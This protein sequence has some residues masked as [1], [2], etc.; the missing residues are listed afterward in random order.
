MRR[1]DILYLSKGDKEFQEIIKDII[2][3]PEVQK[4]KNYKVHGNTTCFAHCYSVS[5]FCYLSCKRH[6][7]DYK[8]AARAGM[9]HDFYLY[10]WRVKNSHVGLHAFTHPFTAYQ[11]AKKQFKL[12]WME[13]EL[14]LTHMWPVTFF[15]IPLCFEGFILTHVDKQCAFHEF[16]NSIKTKFTKAA[17]A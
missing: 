2:N 14:I 5:Y 11:N 13:K 1:E 17:H 9:L 12:N 8:S 3:N 16:V 4:M 6:K 7:L 10:D 15:T